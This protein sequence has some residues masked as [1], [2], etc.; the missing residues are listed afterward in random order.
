MVESIVN[1]V[2]PYFFKVYILGEGEES[3]QWLDLPGRTVEQLFLSHV[4]KVA[5]AIKATWPHMTIIMW[6][7]MMRSMSQD[8]L[9]GEEEIEVAPTKPKRSLIFQT[10]NKLLKKDRGIVVAVLTHSDLI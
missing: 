10:Y 4:T 6:D 5:K 9:K 2:V 8:T 7:D 1:S 3:K